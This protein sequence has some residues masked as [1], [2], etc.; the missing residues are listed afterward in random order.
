MKRVL[1]ALVGIV[2]DPKLTGAAAPPNWS[3]FTAIQGA[4]RVMQVGLR[5]SF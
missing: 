2:L 1:I 4:P 3:N 5:Y